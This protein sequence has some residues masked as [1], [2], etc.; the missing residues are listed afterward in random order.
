MVFWSWVGERHAVLHSDGCSF[1]SKGSRPTG[2]PPGFLRLRALKAIVVTLSLTTTALDWVS[3][4]HFVYSLGA[5]ALSAKDKKCDCH[6]H[7]DGGAVAPAAVGECGALE[8]LVEAGLRSP[9]T[10]PSC[11]EC[12]ALAGCQ[13]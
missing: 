4:A 3:V 7:F 11:A 5:G 10:C 8:R 2:R 13:S 9:I 1:F 6:C 12:P